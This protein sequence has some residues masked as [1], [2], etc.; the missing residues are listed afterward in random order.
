M[1]FRS[2]LLGPGHPVPWM[3]P[4]RVSMKATMWVSVKIHPPGDRRFRSMFP[5][6]RVPFW[7]YPT[8]DPGAS[9]DVGSVSKNWGA[10]FGFPCKVAPEAGAPKQ[11]KPP[12]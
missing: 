2:I 8:F 3:F 7:G 12:V 5:P 10:P 9:E 1:E 4:G 11:D 6:T